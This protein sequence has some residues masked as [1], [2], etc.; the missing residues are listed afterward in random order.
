MLLVAGAVGLAFLTMRNAGAA[1]D[2][3]IV[4]GDQQYFDP[5][6]YIGN[7][8]TGGNTTSDNT[9][10]SETVDNTDNGS[11]DN[12]DNGGAVPAGFNQGAVNLAAFLKMIRVIETGDKYNAIVGGGTFD[13]YNEH[14]WVLNPNLPL[15]MNSNASGAYQF[16]ARIP[17]LPNSPNTWQAAR[18]AAG[19]RDFSPRSQ[20]AAATQLLK[21]RGAYADVIA[22]RF[23][24]AIAKLP[25]EWESL[26]KIFQG[27]YPYTLADI[28][29]IYKTAGGSTTAGSTVV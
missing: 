29:G 24:A 25:Q 16:I 20:D 4:A 14:P 3:N 17:R 26:A 23:N 10:G 13:N 27:N 18:D 15:I 22:G 28:Q 9:T 19:V 2:Q 5:W 21:W 11:A 6:D 8:N 12:A 7:D 1:I